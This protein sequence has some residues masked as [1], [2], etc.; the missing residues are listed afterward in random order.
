MAADAHVTLRQAVETDALAVAELHI[1]AWQWAYRGQL[2][3]AYLD[4][5]T[6]ELERRTAWWRETLSQGRAE[7]RTWVA[8]MAGRIVGFAST[9]PTQN[10]DTAGGTAELYAIY[11]DQTVVGR[12]IGAALL[13]RA[14]ADLRQRGYQAATLWVLATNERARSFYEAAGWRPDGATKTEQRPGLELHEVRY[15]IDLSSVGR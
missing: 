7:A 12:G 2:P 6:A 14:M 11:L 8:D 15:T 13:A 1:R 5:L 10:A 9:G 4:G 3:D